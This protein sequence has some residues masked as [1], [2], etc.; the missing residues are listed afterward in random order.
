MLS[1][2]DGEASQSA[3]LEI[4]RFAQDDG[5]S[6]PPSV[7]FLLRRAGHRRQP[8]RVLRRQRR[9]R[10]ERLQPP[11]VGLLAHGQPFLDLLNLALLHAPISCD[12]W[13]IPSTNFRLPPCDGWRTFTCS[14]PSFSSDDAA[15]L[16]IAATRS[17]GKSRSSHSMK[18]RPAASSPDVGRRFENGLPSACGWNGK[19]FHKSGSGSMWRMVAHTI[20]ALAS[21]DGLGVA[22]ARRNP[23]HSPST[24]PAPQSISDSLTNG[25]PVSRPP[26]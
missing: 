20:V 4:L 26:R 12:S 7:E 24:P 9:R 2:E 18:R 17:I 21:V 23:L 6:I 15:A 19:A 22:V 14:T 13:A 25:M 1:R 10:A 8:H 16:P 5:I 3:H 11:P